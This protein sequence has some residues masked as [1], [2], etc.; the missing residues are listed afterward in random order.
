MNKFKTDHTA[1]QASADPL[2][3]L[4]RKQFAG[5][6]EA[7]RRDV[8]AA[9]HM[10]LMAQLLPFTEGRSEAAIQLG[11]SDALVLG[12]VATVLALWWHDASA[13][14]RTLL[15]LNLSQAA[16][17][18]DLAL[19]GAMLAFALSWTSTVGRGS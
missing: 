3:A 17:A 14:L 10:L 12:A 19:V 16:W 8:P 18:A 9:E 4:L 11:L 2:G 5:E 1:P 13:G 15:Q 7:Q 6:I